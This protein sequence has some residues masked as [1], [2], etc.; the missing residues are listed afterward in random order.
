[1]FS[2]TSLLLALLAAGA[3]EPVRV[4][5]LEPPGPWG[6]RVAAGA[7]AAAASVNAQGGIAGRRLEVVRLDPGR[8]WRDGPRRVARLIL[9]QDLVALI[10]PTDAVAAHEAAQV[11]TKL[12]RPLITLSPEGSLTA[13][14]DPWILRIVPSDRAQAREVLERHF[15]LPAGASARLVVPAGRA[16]RERAAALRAACAE[17]SVRVVAVD[18]PAERPA[19]STS[20]PTADVLL[21]WLDATEARAFLRAG[22]AAGASRVLAG[23]GLA[24]LRAECPA[25]VLPALGAIEDLPFAL[26]HDA[27]TSLAAAARAGGCAPRAMR[28]GLLDAEPFAGRSGR[29]RFDARGQRVDEPARPPATTAPLSPSN[30]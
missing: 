24:P 10:G 1:M 28:D 16:G 17:L 5:L 7:E 30:P 15:A 20:A 21:L 4:G 3:A 14:G 19:G 9:E 11:A 22:G 6:D 12:C 2:P 8:P 23:L 25:L 13:V 18:R 27:L 29:F 26:G